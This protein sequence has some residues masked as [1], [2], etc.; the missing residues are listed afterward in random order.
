MADDANNY[1][2]HLVESHL[3]HLTEQLE[4][5][6]RKIDEQMNKHIQDIQSL[7]RQ[8]TQ[9]HQNAHTEIYSQREKLSLLDEQISE[10]SESIERQSQYLS[11]AIHQVIGNL[12][13]IQ[14]EKSNRRKDQSA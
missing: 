12:P 8:I 4:A 1:D 2:D 14:P 13:D 11:Q 5:Q 10:I 6:R 9:Q 3:N 7:S